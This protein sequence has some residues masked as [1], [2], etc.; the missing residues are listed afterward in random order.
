MLKRSVT[1]RC[2]PTYV[3]AYSPALCMLR[4]VTALRACIAFYV[5]L[6]FVVNTVSGV[7]V[8]LHLIGPYWHAA[9][10]CD[11]VIHGMVWHIDDF[12]PIPNDRHI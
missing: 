10:L 12:Q 6:A 9:L 4:C 1:L 2:V 8:G 3:V 5:N 11:L 7:R